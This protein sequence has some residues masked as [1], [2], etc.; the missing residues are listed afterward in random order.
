MKLSYRWLKEYCDFDLSVKDLCERFTVAGLEVEG[1]SDV[2]DDVMIEIE[3]TADRPD[4]LSHLG[5][6][7]EI[8][9]MVG[10]ELRVPEIQLTESDKPASDF[11]S[12]DILDPALCPRYTARI[13]TDVKVAPSPKWLQDHIETVGLRSVNNVVDITNFVLME[14]GQPLHAF[15]YDKLNENRIIVRLASKGEKMMMIDQTDKELND[16]T[17][18]IADAKRPVA[19]AGVMGGL[20]S[21]VSDSATTILLESAYF[22]PKCVRRGSR[23]LALHTDASYRFERGVDPEIVEW[24]SRRCA[25]MIAEIAGGTVA[26][27]MIDVNHMEPWNRQ[28]SLRVPRIKR[29]LGTEVPADN[30]KRMMSSIGFEIISSADGM[31]EM[32]VPSFRED[33]ATEIDV[34]AEVA[35]LYG[36][37]NISDQSNLTVQ[38]GTVPEWEQV[39]NLARSVV[40]SLGYTE[41]TCSSLVSVEQA[42]KP[43]Y[44][45]QD[46][47]LALSNPLNPNE[48]AMRRML[49]PSLLEVKSLNQDKGTARTEVFE[50]AN[51]YTR[52]ELKPL[53]DEKTCLAIIGEDTFY[54]L[55][56][57]VEIL[58]DRLGLAGKW[59]L[60]PAQVPLLDPN[61]CAKITLEGETL[62]Y[63]GQIDKD[64]IADRDL[65][66]APFGCEL[67]FDLIEKKACLTR[68]FVELPK[69]PAVDRD[70]AVVVDEAVVWLDIQSCVEKTAGELL[71]SVSFFDLYRGKQIGPGKKSLAFSLRFR[72]TDRTLRNEEV[73]EVVEQVVA[74]LGTRFNATLRK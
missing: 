68:E 37:D 43:T 70:L 66:S 13:I 34:I 38:I 17:L 33:V 24:A 64:E 12:I 52:P 67:D 72:S 28:V 2:G 23:L 74:E 71:E 44:W 63:M 35:R 7:R 11:A 4:Q 6:A 69:F 58:L 42:S 3:V 10:S 30:I 55:K 56:G 16:D 40:T 48:A 25:A 45:A 19:V 26:A 22:E 32:K 51:V 31:I 39:K 46:G 15:D 59:E 18:V 73:D 60:E 27:G 14:C 41:V 5:V 53:P 47:I 29:V 50:I 9:A 57:T 61:I 8:A 36:Y 65:R 62:G 54:D 21:E 1:Y 20:D 49:L